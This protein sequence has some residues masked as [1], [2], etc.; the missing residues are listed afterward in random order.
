MKR[1]YKFK[2]KK[3]RKKTR[4]IRHHQ[5]KFEILEEMFDVDFD[6]PIHEILL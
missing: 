3:K 6:N 4:R 5:I 2:I 1:K